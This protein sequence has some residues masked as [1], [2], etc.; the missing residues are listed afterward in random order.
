MNETFRRRI[1]L[2]LQLFLSPFGRIRPGPYW[3]GLLA[4]GLIGMAVT[5]RYGMLSLQ[6][7]VFSKISVGTA[8]WSTLLLQTPGPGAGI[9]CSPEGCRP[10]GTLIAFEIVAV[11]CF[12]AFCLQAKRL[13][14]AGHTAL[15]II[16]FALFEFLAPFGLG[17]LTKAIFRPEDMRGFVFAIGG[18]MFVGLVI[19][20]VFKL[21]IGF[22]RSV[23][24]SNEHG[25]QPGPWDVTRP[26]A[27]RFALMRKR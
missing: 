23:P 21:W 25:A 11:F 13:H 26:E 10:W 8:A 24:G 16:V 5:A 12:S 20:V 18:G 9:A 19:P 22:A 14:D 6:P 27:R 7:G 2:I 1:L 4:L 17:L 15:W 3:L